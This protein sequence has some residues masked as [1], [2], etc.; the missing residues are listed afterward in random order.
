VLL[1]EISQPGGCASVDRAAHFGLDLPQAE[2]LFFQNLEFH[3]HL[4]GYQGC[5]AKKQP[6]SQTGVSIFN[7]RP[8][9]N[10]HPLLIPAS[11]QAENVAKN[12]CA[13]PLN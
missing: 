12:I 6:S 10:L 1:R 7:R 13:W 11:P 9:I 8:C 5:S 4:V 2:A 3:I